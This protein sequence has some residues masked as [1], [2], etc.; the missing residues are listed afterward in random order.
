MCRVDRQGTRSYGA[1]AGT[2]RIWCEAL[3]VTK[4]WGFRSY[5]VP[6][7]GLIVQA[8]AARSAVRCQVGRAGRHSYPPFPLAL[9]PFSVDLHPPSS[10]HQQHHP[11]VPNAFILV[12]LLRPRCNPLRPYSHRLAAAVIPHTIRTTPP[13]GPCRSFRMNQA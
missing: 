3:V 1:N 6:K 11:Y 4:S 10:Q 9:S 7:L 5:F 13:S 12:L 8:N 2:R